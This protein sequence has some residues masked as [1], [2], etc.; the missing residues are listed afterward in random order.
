[1]SKCVGID[2]YNTH[3]SSNLYSCVLYYLVSTV[4]VCCAG[5]FSGIS[6]VTVNFSVFAKFASQSFETVSRVFSPS[7]EVKMMSG[8]TVIISALFFASVVLATVHGE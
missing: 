8:Q 4:C 2:M 5:K 1:M 3:T 6:S 7:K